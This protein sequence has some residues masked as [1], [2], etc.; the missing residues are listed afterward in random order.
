MTIDKAPAELRHYLWTGLDLKRFEVL[1]IVP[2]TENEA[3]IVMRDG[4]K[5]SV[6]PWCVEYRGS[7]KYF[8]SLELLNE[9]CKMRWHFFI[10]EWGYSCC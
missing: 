6:K 8:E 3:V 4:M 10:S 5:D 7:G 2:E 1:T 9:Y